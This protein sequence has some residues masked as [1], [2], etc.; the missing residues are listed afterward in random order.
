MGRSSTGRSRRGADRE[1][2]RSRRA[3]TDAEAFEWP[4]VTAANACRTGRAGGPSPAVE[5][6]ARGDSARSGSAVL[7]GA[8]ATERTVG[9]LSPVAAL[10]LR[11][12]EGATGP[13]KKV[14]SARSSSVVAQPLGN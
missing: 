12:E 1:R 5:G 10:E 7:A 4:A 3:S 14:A 13:R 6:A 8:D 11:P 9:A 2:W